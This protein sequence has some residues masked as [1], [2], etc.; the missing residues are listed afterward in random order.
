MSVCILFFHPLI[1]FE[2]TWKHNF[3]IGKAMLNLIGKQLCYFPLKTSKTNQTKTRI[4]LLLSLE[5]KKMKKTF[6]QH[7]IIII[8]VILDFKDSFFFP[9]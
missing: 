5:F 8:I 9:A 1:A 7:F 3:V 4:A 2:E 6:Y